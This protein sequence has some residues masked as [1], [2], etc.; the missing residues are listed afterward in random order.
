MSREQDSQQPAEVRTHVVIPTH[1]PRYLDLVLA[2]LARQTHRPATVTVTCDT[3]RDD[4]GGAI[5]RA[6][7]EFALPVAWVRRA[8]MGGERLCQIRNNA[9]RVL[10]QHLGIDAARRPDPRAIDRAAAGHRIVTLDGD[11]IAPDDL[12]AKHAAIHESAA[13]AGLEPPLIYAYRV[14]VDE[15]R[16]AALDARALF[17]RGPEALGLMPAP[18][19]LQ[20]LDARERR[21]RKHLRMRSVGLGP[22]RL[23][24]R[25][26]PKLLG[27]HYSCTLDQ[28]LRL[29]GFD[30]H[31]QG[32]GFK[33]DEFA[34]RAARLHMPVAV[35]VRAIPAFHLY[36]TTRQAETPM[37]ELPNAKRF[38]ER[39][40]LPL[41]CERG[42]NDPIEQAAVRV[43]R[44]G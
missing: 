28:Y 20:T 40:R 13:S 8:H 37:R 4:I 33:D 44:F 42:V 23:G 6:A 36:H 5:E 21:Y 38:A 22:V 35:G 12:L 3:D 18:R 25:H 43:T 14:D 10:A 24:P 30:E 2:G 39:A 9:A 31:Y 29:N 15:E 7:H 17:E 32:W 26:K 1:L 19:D 11:M 16:S 34:Y 41:V 27:G